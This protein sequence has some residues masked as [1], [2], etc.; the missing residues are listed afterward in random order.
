L[1]KPR[2]VLITETARRPAIETPLGHRK[3]PLT[4]SVVP[5]S[6]VISVHGAPMVFVSDTDY[7]F[8]ATPVV[9]GESANDGQRILSGVLV[10]QVVVTDGAEALKERLTL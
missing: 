4:G 6:A 3:I 1:D 2:P 7:H 5:S 8:V 10:G 9:L